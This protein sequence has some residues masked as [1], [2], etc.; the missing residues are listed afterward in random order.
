MQEIRRYEFYLFN[1]H[2][3]FMNKKGHQSNNFLIKL[4]NSQ[5]ILKYF[6]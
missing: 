4:M 2:L 3:I 5:E 1:L 6:H